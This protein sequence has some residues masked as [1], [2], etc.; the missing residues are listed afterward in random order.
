MKEFLLKR[1]QGNERNL[2]RKTNSQGDIKTT[3]IISSIS[4]G[5]EV[6][7]R[8]APEVKKN[9]FLNQI[10]GLESVSE[11]CSLS[12]KILISK[13]DLPTYEFLGSLFRQ[14]KYEKVF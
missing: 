8:N 5:E 9:L 13:C 7:D 6:K 4:H 3:I 11:D 1:K 10:S 2:Y 14:S 12:K